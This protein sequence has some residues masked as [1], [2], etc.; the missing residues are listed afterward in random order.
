MSNPPE[1]ILQLSPGDL[2]AWI[3]PRIAGELAFDS[4]FNWHGLAEMT[5]MHA[6]TCEESAVWAEIAVRV[7]AWLA[8]NSEPRIANGF[9][10]SEIYVRAHQITKFGSCSGHITRDS[11]YLVKWFQKSCEL[12]YAQAVAMSAD[13]RHLSREEILELRSIKNYLGVFVRLL[14]HLNLSDRKELQNWLELRPNLP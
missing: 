14:G 1:K 4:G 3:Q 5:A 7:Y 13:W 10:V 2:L 8:E 9:R 6:R 12:S 11:Q